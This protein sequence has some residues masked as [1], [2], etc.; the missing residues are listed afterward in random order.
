VL[1]EPGVSER[2][3]EWRKKAERGGAFNVLVFRVQLDRIY[4]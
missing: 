2:L 4:R 1:L 3:V